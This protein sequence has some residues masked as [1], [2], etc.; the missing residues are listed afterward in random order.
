MADR[1]LE[2]FETR[3]IAGARTA[4]LVFAKRESDLMGGLVSAGNQVTA[5]SATEIL[6]KGGNAVDAAVC[7]THVRIATSHA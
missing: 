4:E 7:G 5:D 6:G 2:T 3:S 1:T